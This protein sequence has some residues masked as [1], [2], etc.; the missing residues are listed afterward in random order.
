MC[1]IVST[2]RRRNYSCL[3]H[4]DQLQTLMMTTGV[5]N[6]LLLTNNIMPWTEWFNDVLV[7]VTTETLYNDL[8]GANKYR[9]F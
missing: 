4:Y 1:N 6:I 7:P 3:I 8:Y 9:V 2:N 5:M